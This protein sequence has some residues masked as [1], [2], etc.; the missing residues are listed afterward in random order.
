MP[1]KA[2]SHEFPEPLPGFGF[3]RDSGQLGGEVV[4]EDAFHARA[5]EIFRQA[6]AE[7]WVLLTANAVVFE[8]HALLLTRSRNGGEASRRFLDV[9]ERGICAIERVTAADESAAI[10]L[11]RA[12]RD[13]SY[14]FCDALSFVVMERLGIDAAIA[15]DSHF[16]QYGRMRLL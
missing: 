6:R 2:R 12:H 15:F 11:I 7:G 8:T 9:V 14:S 4:R 16:R 3:L 13:K 1:R 10:A 5:D